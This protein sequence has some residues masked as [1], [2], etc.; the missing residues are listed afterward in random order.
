MKR[1][2]VG[3]LQLWPAIFSLVVPTL[4]LAQPIINPFGPG[5][6]GLPGGGGGA[7]TTYQGVFYLGCTIVNLLFGVLVFLTILFVVLAAYKYLTSAGDPEKVKEASKQ[8]LYAAISI[9]VALLAKALPA[10]ISSIVQAPVYYLFP[11]CA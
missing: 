3:A 11:G 9:I 7:P 1:I 8:L 6:G 2:L 10:I 4:A 5:T